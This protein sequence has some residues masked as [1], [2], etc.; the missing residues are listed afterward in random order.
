M[1]PKRDRGLL[2]GLKEMAGS[3]ALLMNADLLMAF[4]AAAKPAAFY[5]FG[6]RTYSHFQLP[7]LVFRAPSFAYILGALTETGNCKSCRTPGAEIRLPFL[8]QIV[9]IEMQWFI[10][11]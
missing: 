4:R 11:Q 2:L 6:S 10:K 7:W 1:R 3:A 8:L 5:L 9:A